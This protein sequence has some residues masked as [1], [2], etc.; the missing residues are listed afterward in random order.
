MVRSSFTFIAVAWLASLAACSGCDP[1]KDTGGGGTCGQAG[2]GCAVA[3]DCCSGYCS[4]SG[5]CATAPV[6]GAENASCSVN[7]DCCT[8]QGLTCQ[9]S[10]CQPFV[11]KN[12]NDS[13]V[14]PS[15]CCAVTG[16]TCYQN[17]CQPETVCIGDNAA[18]TSTGKACCGS[19]ICDL[20]S[21]TPTSTCSPNACIEDGL[22]CNAKEP[23]CS[24][25]CNTATN[26]CPTNT[27]T[28]RQPGAGCTTGS[29]CCSGSC[30]TQTATCKAAACLPTPEPCTDP[31]QCCSG[32]GSCSSIS[33]GSC[34]VVP[35]GTVANDVC[36]TLG[37]TC[38]VGSDCCSTNCKS[39]KCAAAY[40]CNASGD[41]CYK[42][43]DC[44]SGTCD[45]S[46]TTSLAGR[47]VRPNGGCIQDGNPCSGSTGCCTR[48]CADPG[49][50]VTVCMPAGGCRMTGDFC[51]S[52][53]ACCG[54]YPDTMRPD[55]YNIECKSSV[56][57]PTPRC[58][59]GGS[60]NPP[61]NICGVSKDVNASQNCCMPASYG[62]G[63]GK[64]ACKQDDSGIWRCYGGPAVCKNPDGTVGDC[65]TLCPTGFDPTKPECC[66]DDGLACEFNGQC[67]NGNPCIQDSTGAFKCTPPNQACLAAGTTCASGGTP[68][69]DP[70]SCTYV[71][72]FGSIC[73]ATSTTPGCKPVGPTSTCTSDTDCCLGL[74]SGTTT[75]TCATCKATDSACTAGA[76]C[77]GGIC[78]MGVCRDPVCLPAGSSCTSP[79]TAGGCCTPYGCVAT[80]EFGNVC[81]TSNATT[82]CSALK[83]SCATQGCC[84]GFCTLDPA[85][86]T[87]TVCETCKTDGDTCTAGT[88]CCTGYCDPAINKCAQQCVASGGVCSNNGDCC[89]GSTCVIPGGSSSGTCEAASYCKSVGG[90]CLVNTDCC[91]YGS[92]GALQCDTSTYTC[93]YPVSTCSNSGGGCGVG[94]TDT[95]CCTGT[96]L[97]CTTLDSGGSQVACTGTAADTVPCTCNVPCSNQ[98]GPCGGT[99]PSCCT[100]TTGSLSCVSG[101]CQPPT[102]CATPVGATCSTTK[103]CCATDG[104]YCSET[105]P[106]N[107]K[108]VCSGTSTSCVCVNPG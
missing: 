2:A 97:S 9:G 80:P 99:N 67:C 29:Q 41:I 72:E 55:G 43:T 28:C 107:S 42:G 17:K 35:P 14:N 49:S 87:G 23:C 44:C 33:S 50:G 38:T 77:C 32:T 7:A 56:S 57:D 104:T 61:G 10:K 13:C 88:Q 86:G 102:T 26:K 84:T 62:G 12:V 103:P 4:P 19:S 16:L 6:C 90:G 92:P 8:A 101:T 89:T 15:D 18:C 75:K 58:N 93:Q 98:G 3:G 70:Y 91:G 76:E 85:T 20:Y 22:T 94:T 1:K 24:G 5:Q 71:P 74:C 79:G 47:C 64:A 108:A 83:T 69:C 31:S 46:N 78:D 66:L 25:P 100:P 65:A 11:C 106:T 73:A 36:K 63:S 95:K 105:A 54:G 21:Q 60:C 48:T 81:T 96:G 59:N 39:G 34:Q 53:G 52:T 40:N 27:G 82:N 51:D 37:E 30:D 68:C 45:L